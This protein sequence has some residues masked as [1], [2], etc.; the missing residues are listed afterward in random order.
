MRKSL[1]ELPLG[2][3]NMGQGDRITVERRGTTVR[4]PTVAGSEAIVVQDL[5]KWYGDIHAVDGLSFSVKQGEIF[6]L[7]GPNGAGKTTT[8]EILEGYRRPDKGF[9]RV[10]GLDPI[11]QGA[12]LK[13]RMGLMLQ[14]TGLYDLIKVGEAVELFCSYYEHPADPDHLI[15][16][17]G[18]ESHRRSYFKTLSGGQKQRLSLALALAG[19]PELVF[20]DEPTA[21]MDPQARLLTWELIEQFR[22]QGMTVMLT[23]HYMEEAQRLADRVAI[24]DHGRLVVIGTPEE[25]TQGAGSEI[26]RFTGPEGLDLATLEQLPC[27]NQASSPR[28]GSYAIVTTDAFVLVPALAAWAKQHNIALSNLRVEGATLEDIFLR[29]T[30]EE[31]RD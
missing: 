23:T 29:V 24:I 20:L 4:K 12:Q 25:L 18:L 28:P 17:V 27:A 9:V 15:R 10:L 6:A 7:L 22:Q 14:Q 3:E 31:V 21:G 26:V 11:V 2:M 13:Q 1:L 16:L 30:G 5:V 19:N 8:I